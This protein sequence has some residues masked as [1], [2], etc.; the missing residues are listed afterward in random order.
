[1]PEARISTTPVVAEYQSA[2]ALSGEKLQDFEQGGIALGDPTQGLNVQTWE[3]RV[4]GNDV[5]VRPLGGTYTTVFTEAGIQEIGLAFDQNMNPTIAYRAGGVCKLRWYDP[6]PGNQRFVT[7][8][9]PG[10]RDIRICLDDKR[11]ERRDFSD[12]LVFYLKDAPDAYRQTVYMRMQRDRY[13]VEY[14]IGQLPVGANA[15]YKVGMAKNYRLKFSVW[16]LFAPA[17]QPRREIPPFPP[18]VP[19]EPG[20]VMDFRDAKSPYYGGA[21]YT[22]VDF[23][24][25]LYK[26]PL[27][28]ILP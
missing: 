7:T 18:D 25:E 24:F 8:S 14:N 4:L 17:A 16:G 1:M 12:I 26:P 21:G 20:L 28:D 3:L 6:T 11:P 13:L 9:Y 2:D 5:R 22:V 23:D 27:S 19:V 10:T 15:L